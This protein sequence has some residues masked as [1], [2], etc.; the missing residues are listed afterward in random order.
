MEYAVAQRDTW[1]DETVHILVLGHDGFTDEHKE[2]TLFTREQAKVVCNL[3]NK[4]SKIHTFP[5]KIK[6]EHL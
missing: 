6:E 2:A 3:L 4:I 5:K 1:W